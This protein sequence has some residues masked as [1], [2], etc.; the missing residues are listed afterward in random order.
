MS[1]ATS[2]CSAP[3]IEGD[4]AA[5]RVADNQ[6]VAAGRAADRAGFRAVARP[7]GAGGGEPRR[8][9]RGDRH[10]PP[11]GPAAAGAD[12]G[13][14]GAAR[15]G[16]GRAGA[17]RRRC[18]PRPGSWS[19]RAGPSR[20]AADRATSE[21]RKADAGV[22]AA[23]AQK[24]AAE[25]QLDVLQAGWCRQQARQQTRPRRSPRLAREQPRLHRHPRAVRRHRRQPRG[26]ARPARRTGHAADRRGAAARAALRQSPISRRRSCRACSP[27]SRC[28]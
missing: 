7:A 18:P 10:Q 23:A 22:G 26:A 16:A 24:S 9:R 8:G 4:V 20:Q 27:G 5:I 17:R 14:R 19:G 2:P 15:T 3:R 11:A 1:R 28:G 25:Q 6:R 13:G 21:I 12:R